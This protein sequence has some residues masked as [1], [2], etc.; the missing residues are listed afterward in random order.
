MENNLLAKCDKVQCTGK[1]FKCP[2]SYCI[3]MRH[4]CNGHWNCPGGQD[5]KNCL[6][7]TC[8]G[9]FKCHNSSL[10]ISQDSICDGIPDCIF[11]DDNTFCHLPICPNHCNCLLNSISCMNI[12]LTH[13]TQIG[14]GKTEHYFFTRISFSGITSL[15]NLLKQFICSVILIIPYNNLHDPCASKHQNYTAYLDISH[16]S[17]KSLHKNCFTSMLDLR[18]IHLAFNQIDFLESKCFYKLE[19]LIIVNLTSNPLLTIS[20][21]AFEGSVIK[22]VYVDISRICC[23]LFLECRPASNK[24]SQCRYTLLSDNELAVMMKVGC[25]G[26]ALEVSVIV[27]QVLDLGNQ[28]GFNYRATIIDITIGDFL[29]SVHILIISLAD[30]IFGQSYFEQ[31]IFWKKSS[32]CFVSAGFFYCSCFN[33]SLCNIYFNHFK[34]TSR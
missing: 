8:S 19:Q 34:A 12:S 6:N 21:S 30:I 28:G 23:I 2:K 17:V 26:I 24:T 4:E 22:N 20:A 31:E 1:Y 14:R 16:N 29:Y 33:I 3:P 15:S 25:C 11:Q 27:V 9:R 18:E 32:F 5:E 13:I 10:C 7:R